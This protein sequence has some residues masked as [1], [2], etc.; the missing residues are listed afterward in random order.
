MISQD[1]K[2]PG[3]WFACACAYPLTESGAAKTGDTGAPEGD[4]PQKEKLA[5]R[6]RLTRGGASSGSETDGRRSGSWPRVLGHVAA[7]VEIEKN[8][9]R[10]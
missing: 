5:P 1:Q 4:L 7:D 9:D 8:A 2:D 6:D 3:E 10:E